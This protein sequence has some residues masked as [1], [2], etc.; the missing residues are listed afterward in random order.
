ML[1]P[2]EQQTTELILIDSR[3]NIPPP[4]PFTQPIAHL[5]LYHLTRPKASRHV[6]SRCRL[7]SS[8]RGY[9]HNWAMLVLVLTSKDFYGGSAV[10][11]MES[12]SKI[13]G[14][15]CDWANVS[16]HSYV[17]Q[18]LFRLLYSSSSLF[19]LPLQRKRKTGFVG[20]YIWFYFDDVPRRWTWLTGGGGGGGGSSLDLKIKSVQSCTFLFHL[21]EKTTFAI[22]TKNETSFYIFITKICFLTNL[23]I[24]CLR[25]FLFA[26]VEIELNYFFLSN[27][28]SFFKNSMNL[29]IN[30]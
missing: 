1:L 19:F 23:S 5:R 29:I 22:H 18:H 2:L 27:Y 9:C 11:E 25:L 7:E 21:F 12:Q 26:G 13:G 8:A 3:N 6:T 16:S 10:A 24:H 14:S 4:L 30:K 28:Y 17:W 15:V 20:S